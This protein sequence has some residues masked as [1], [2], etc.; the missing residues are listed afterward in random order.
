M[1]I[2]VTRIHWS[3]LYVI[4]LKLSPKDA[5]VPFNIAMIADSQIVIL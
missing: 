3:A 4:N 1:V 2:V 5:V